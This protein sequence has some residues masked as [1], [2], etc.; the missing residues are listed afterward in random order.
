MEQGEERLYTSFQQPVHQPV[1]EVQAGLVDGTPTLWHHPG[2]R[3][4]EAIGRQSK[5]LHDP[6]VV[7]P[8]VVVIAGHITGVAVEHP[9]GDP[10]ETVPNALRPAVLGHR[11]LDLVGGRGRAPQEIVGE[12]PGH[13][14]STAPSRLSSARTPST[15]PLAPERVAASKVPS[16]GTR[17]GS[18]P[19]LR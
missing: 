9:S 8:P 19:K 2:P 16:A 7:A 12:P 13:V 4:R 14:P 11:S 1:V 5:V 17:T 15:G 10:A 3:R 18:S 6:D